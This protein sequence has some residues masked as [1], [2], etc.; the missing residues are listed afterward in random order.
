M[1]G[2]FFRSQSNFRCGFLKIKNSLY[3][4]GVDSLWVESPGQI[5]AVCRKKKEK[6]QF[7]S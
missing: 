1:R 5:K 7:F 3:S 2:L 6:K 4:T